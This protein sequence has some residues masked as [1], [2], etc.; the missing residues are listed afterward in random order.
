MQWA[1][2][3]SKGAE[4]LRLYLPFIRA[5]LRHGIANRVTKRLSYSEGEM[6]LGS[7]SYICWR[8]GGSPASHQGGYTH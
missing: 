3:I 6:R 7:W 4:A 8:S 1:R 5:I 2:T